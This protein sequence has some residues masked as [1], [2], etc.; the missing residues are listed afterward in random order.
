MSVEALK[1]IYLKPLVAFLLIVQCAFLVFT[2]SS[3]LKTNGDLR[4][5]I[6]S[7]RNASQSNI[8][9]LDQNEARE[10]RLTLESLAS[11]QKSNTTGTLLFSLVSIVL[12]VIIITPLR[13][14]RSPEK[15]ER[16]RPCVEF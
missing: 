11:N 4:G 2:W 13:F 6:S 12:M 3:T 14:M 9:R 1:Q 10:I 8:A 5:A 7:L 15:L 16:D